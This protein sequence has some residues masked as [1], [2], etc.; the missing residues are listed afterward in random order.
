[1][2]PHRHLLGAALI[3]AALTAGPWVGAAAAGGGN[4]GGGMGYDPHHANGVYCV[5][6]AP[7]IVLVTYRYPVFVLGHGFVPLVIDWGDGTRSTLP[8][9]PT[10]HPWD[11]FQP[12]QVQH[13][14]PAK[15]DVTGKGIT[16][17]EHDG[18]GG[19]LVKLLLIRLVAQCPPPPETPEAP[20]ALL[21]PLGALA[22]IGVV[23][24]RR[25]RRAHRQPVAG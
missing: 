21:L 24:W 16:D 15:F 8:T 13:T 18:Y 25:G 17:N 2:R 1:M 3:V 19:R 20:Y 22:I 6:R 4:G 11:A 23:V 14:Y 12:Y 5:A 10:R 9:R 7:F